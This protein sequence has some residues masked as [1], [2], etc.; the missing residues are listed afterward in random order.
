MH[1]SHILVALAWM[2]LVIGC[3]RTPENLSICTAANSP[4][5]ICGLMN[6]ED[7]DFLPG[8]AWIVVSQMAPAEAGSPPE[9]P[10]NLLAIRLADGLRKTLFPASY[11]WGTSGRPRGRV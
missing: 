3:G 7:L 9:R 5:S 10:G 11:A 4:N 6:P 1:R 8:R 2:G